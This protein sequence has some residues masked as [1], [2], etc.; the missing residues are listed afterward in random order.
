MTDRSH[1]SQ[2]AAA[3]TDREIVAVRVFDAPRE[4]V[5][6]MWTDPRHVVRWWGPIGFTTTIDEMDVRPGGVWRF[7]LHGP[8]GRAYKNKI[9]YV[10]IETPSRIVYDHVSGPQFRTMATFADKAGKTE[11]TVRMVFKT[12]AERDKTA[13]EFGAVE[14]LHQTLGRLGD[15]LAGS[16]PAD[17]PFV[18]SRVFDAPRERVFEA[19]TR[20]EHLMKWFGPK[21]FTMPYAKLDLRPGGTFH[22]QLRS[23]AGQE[24]WGRFLFREIAPPDRLVFVNSFSD[25]AGGLTRHPGN[26]VWPLT[27]ITTVTFAAQGG[28]TLVTVEWAPLNA[29]DEERTTFD[30]GRDSMRGGWTGTFEQ[31]ADFLA[32]K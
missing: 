29:T 11:V 12:A 8:D 9:V 7:V 26:E 17:R 30:A 28:K 6:R 4:L 23:P 31:L 1:Q 19:W 5:F 32:G 25:E 10:E 27:M 2:D 22:Y 20:Q 24:L 3:A 21:G 14:G 18:I 16:G 13:R 15:Q